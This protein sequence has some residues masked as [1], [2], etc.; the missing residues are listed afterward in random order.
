M[1]IKRLQAMKESTPGLNDDLVVTISSA[2]IF[3]KKK[4][5]KGKNLQKRSPNY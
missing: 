2:E 1:Q 5:K 4:K 3:V